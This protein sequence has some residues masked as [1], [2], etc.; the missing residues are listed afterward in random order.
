[1]SWMNSFIVAVGTYLVA[2]RGVGVF[3]MNGW[4]TWHS[5]RRS[6]VKLLKRR[7]SGQD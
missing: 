7:T 6:T 4:R 1:M 2:K 3:L 5:L